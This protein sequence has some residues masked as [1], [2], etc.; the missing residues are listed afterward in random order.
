MKLIFLLEFIITIQI[1]TQVLSNVFHHQDING[2]RMLLS[3]NPWKC[4]CLTITHFQV[5]QVKQF[6]DSTIY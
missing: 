3:N 5:I 1:P 4:D 6:A 2:V